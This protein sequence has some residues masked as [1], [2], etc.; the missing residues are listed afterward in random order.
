LGKTPL[1]TG[2]LQEYSPQLRQWRVRDIMLVACNVAGEPHP[3]PLPVNGEGS[4]KG[5]LSFLR[6]LHEIAGAKI[7]ASARRVG[8][9]A[10]G[11]TWELECR[12]GDVSTPLAL[13]PEICQTYPGIFPPS[14]STSTTPA[15]GNNPI[16]VAVGDFNRDG[17]LDLAAANYI[18]STFTAAVG[19]RHRHGIYHFY[20]HYCEQ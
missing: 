14:F 5:G 15:V 16:S 13:L 12:W 18:D 11:G 17:K 4:K 20:H 19:R 10:L 2:N 3:Q 9:Q 6:Q 1:H 7:A 8:N